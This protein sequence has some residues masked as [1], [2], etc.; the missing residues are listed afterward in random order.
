MPEPSWD[1]VTSTRGRRRGFLASAASTSVM[2]GRKLGWLDGVTLGQNDLIADGGLAELLEHRFVG[3]L[4]A[5]TGVDQY[6]D[7]GEIGA[8]AQIGADQ[9]GPGRDLGL[10]GGRIA[11]AGHV[12]DVEG[13]AAGEE[14]Q[15]LSAAGRARGARQGLAAGQCVD[16]ARFAD[17]G[18]AGK[19]DLDATHRRQRDVRT[20]GGDKVPIAG[21]QLAAGLDFVAG[22]VGHR[23]I[24]NEAA[25]HCPATT[26]LDFTQA[27]RL[28]S[29]S[30]RIAP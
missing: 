2:R 16:Q 12:H 8:A 26:A 11:I 21:E 1:E 7:A 29:F 30:S 10:G 25:G 3:V 13:R 20:G 22:E 4:E 9:R 15:L 24:I 28:A 6:I 19:G 14:D 23:S 27:A 5:V 18:A 17:I